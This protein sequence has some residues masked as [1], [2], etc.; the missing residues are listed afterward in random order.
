MS[1]GGHDD[2]IEG[3][4]ESGLSPKAL[5]IDQRLSKCVNR[6]WDLIFP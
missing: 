5:T 4:G 2:K 3:N 1:F 6:T